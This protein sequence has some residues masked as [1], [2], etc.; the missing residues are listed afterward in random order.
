MKLHWFKYLVY[1]SIVFL[2]VALVRAD[3]LKLPVVYS[4][5]DLAFS[6]F[7]IFIAMLLAGI[8]WKLLLKKYEMEISYGHGIASFGL[9]I[10]TK[11]IPG[12]LMVVLGKAGYVNKQYKYANDQLITASFNDQMI[13]LWSGFI[14]GSIGLLFASEFFVYGLIMAG[15]LIVFSLVLFTRFAYQIFEKIVNRFLKKR[16]ISVP[17]I[18]FRKLAG[19]IPVYFV[20]WFFLAGGFYFL[21]N[22]LSEEACSVLISFAI[23]LATTIG[24]ITLIAPGGLGVREGVITAFLAALGLTAEA[25]LAISVASRLWFLFGETSIFVTSLI[26]DRK[27]RSV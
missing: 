8:R 2:I 17:H 25:A 1:I 26:I 16:K 6:L 21:G 22:A 10:F 20:Y 18:E 14:L 9:S 23:P 5:L 4:Y 19:V 24:I 13:S 27:K 7:F 12:K 3:Y 11:Y 15:I